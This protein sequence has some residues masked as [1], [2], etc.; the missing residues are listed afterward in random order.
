MS[1]RAPLRDRENQVH[2]VH[3]IKHRPRDEVSGGGTPGPRS[4]SR[5]STIPE[6][7]PAHLNPEHHGSDDEREATELRDTS[8]L[9]RPEHQP[10]QQQHWYTPVQQFW[11]HQ[12]Q[13]SVPHVDCRDHLA[14]ERTFLGYLRTS[15]A[16]AIIGAVI[17]QLYRLQNPLPEAGFGYYGVGRPLSAVFHCSALGVTLMGAWRFWQQ[18]SAMAVGKVHAGGWEVLVVMGW[19]IVVSLFDMS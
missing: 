2:R 4:T 15:V 8:H 13:L 12:I 14:N 5:N 18:Q 11:R 1:Y 17:A 6:P 7:E 9:S 10:P 19:S 16:L 3:D